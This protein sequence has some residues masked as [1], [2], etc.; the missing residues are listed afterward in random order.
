MWCTFLVSSLI[1]ALIFLEIFLYS[2]FYCSI[3]IIFDITFLIG[4]KY[5]NIN[6]SKIMKKRYSKKENSICSHLGLENLKNYKLW[7][8]NCSA[9]G[10]TIF[11]VKFYQTISI[12][13]NCTQ[14]CRNYLHN[15]S[16]TFQYMIVQ[17]IC[18]KK[19]QQYTRGYMFCR[20]HLKTFHL[21]IR[22][23]NSSKKNQCLKQTSLFDFYSDSCYNLNVGAYKY[24]TI[25]LSMFILRFHTTKTLR[26]LQLGS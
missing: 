26:L 19:S 14:D 23:A 13:D 8:C 17:G 7:A 3:G 1:T 18:Q 5:K 9:C 16:K 10:F 12:F 24:F 21:A 22:K 15:K 2:V 25:K 11:Q 20:N 4:I 6:I